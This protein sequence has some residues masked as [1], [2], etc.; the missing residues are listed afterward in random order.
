VNGGRVQWKERTEDDWKALDKTFGR[1]VNR[2]QNMAAVRVFRGL[3]AQANRVYQ[4]VETP[5]GVALDRWDAG[6]QTLDRLLLDGIAAGRSYLSLAAG[7]DG[8]YIAARPLGQP[9]WRLAWQ[10][11]EDAKWS[12][13]SDA[14][15]QRL[16]K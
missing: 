16:T 10:G 1:K 11:L 14:V 12:A 5:D 3:T 6:S 9:I 15:S 2:S 4:V 8:L 13:V 7:R